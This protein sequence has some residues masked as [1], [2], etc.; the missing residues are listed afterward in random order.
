MTH[1]PADVRKTIMSKCLLKSSVEQQ[2][3]NTWIA[4]RSSAAG[5]RVANQS[6]IAVYKP[7]SS[8]GGKKSLL[9]DVFRISAPSES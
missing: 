3:R 8:Y 4:A 1:P 6:Y 2:L 7:I 9:A 5:D